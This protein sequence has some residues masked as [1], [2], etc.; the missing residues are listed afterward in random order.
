[1]FYRTSCPLWIFNLSAIF[2]HIWKTV[3]SIMTWWLWQISKSEHNT[4]WAKHYLLMPYS[5]GSNM[6]LWC[7]KWCQITEGNIAEYILKLKQKLVFKLNK[8]VKPPLM[9][10]FW[11]FHGLIR[12]S[13]KFWEQ[14]HE[15][16][17]LHPDSKRGTL[18]M[19]TMHFNL[20]FIC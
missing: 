14:P 13:W 4:S 15:K 5:Q 20:I 8:I 11:I 19:N 17:L 7:F 16:I 3:Y 18:I 9:M 2:L 12:V 6:P 1:M 10:I